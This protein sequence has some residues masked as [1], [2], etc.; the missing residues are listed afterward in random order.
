MA[1]QNEYNPRITK[2]TRRQFDLLGEI[3]SKHDALQPAN[4]IAF[5]AI[6]QPL[7]DDLC[8]IIRDLIDCI[9]DLQK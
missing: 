4:P 1:N 9:D 8:A 3:E 7:V 5:V 2:L 6:D